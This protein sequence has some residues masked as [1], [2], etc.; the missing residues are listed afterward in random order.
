MPRASQDGT[1]GWHLLTGRGGGGKGP[2][3]QAGGRRES[4]AVL[5]PRN[6]ADSECEGQGT[7]GKWPRALGLPSWERDAG[8]GGRRTGREKEGEGGRGGRTEEREEGPGT[9]LWQMPRR[10]FVGG[11]RFSWLAFP[12]GWHR[13]LLA[14]QTGPGSPGWAAFLSGCRVQPAP[15]GEPSGAFEKDKHSQ[16]PREAQPTASPPG[17]TLR[18]LGKGHRPGFAVW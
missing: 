18:D 13:G 2:G 16:K 7:G 6:L 9:V 10:R 14:A 8:G 4:R 12:G 1:P 5:T 11:A 17:P 15:R 3:P